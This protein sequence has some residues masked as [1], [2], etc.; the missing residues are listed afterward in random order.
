M[1]WLACGDFLLAPVRS[2]FTHIVGNPPYVRQELIPEPLL[3]EYRIRFRTLYDRADLYVP[4]FE[5]CLGLLAPSG[6]LGFI[7]TDRWTNKYGGPLRALIA[8]GFELTHFVDLIDTPAFHADVMTYPAITVIQRA[9]GRRKPQPTRVA[10]RPLIEAPTLSAL[11]QAM[12]ARRMPAAGGSIEVSGVTNGAEPWLLQA[13]RQLALVRRLEQAFPTIEEA[14]CKVGIGVA[15]G[16]DS[17]YIRP[18]AAL[19]VEPSRA[20]PLARTQDLCDG[21]IVWKGWG[22]LNPFEKDGSLVNLDRYP[23]FA[24]YLKEHSQAI[25][26]RHVAKRNPERW[27][28]TIDRIYPELTRTPKLLVPDIKAHAHIVYEP[29]RLYTRI[30]ISTSSPQVNRFCSAAS[31]LAIR[32]RPV[33]RRGV[34]YW[35]ARRL[36]ALPSAIPSSNQASIL[37]HSAPGSPGKLYVMQLLP[38]IFEQPISPPASCMGCQRQNKLS[39]RQRGNRWLWT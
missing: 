34:L 28:R 5:R 6:R 32:H 24:R 15:T 2:G 12:T 31:R 14:G 9:Q 36:F 35:H 23:R 21:E 16:N 13:L 29:G 1:R 37:V 33:V 25:K 18:F 39:S 4:F 20:L 8:E 11:A 38:T 19:N 3:A 30:T 26:A 10:Y 17:V 27:F 22:I 7:C